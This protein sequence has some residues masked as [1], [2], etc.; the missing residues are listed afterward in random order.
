MDPY[1]TISRYHIPKLTRPG[2]ELLRHERTH[3]EDELMHR[4]LETV[5]GTDFF[6]TI[7]NYSEGS[8]ED[9]KKT[10]AIGAGTLDNL[11]SGAAT[12]VKPILWPIKGL[13][14]R[15]QM[16]CPNQTTGNP[17]IL[18]CKHWPPTPTAVL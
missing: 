4:A 5:E 17:T 2:V 7:L 12:I 3:H 9:G 18:S 14:T 10:I 8:S 16:G 15:R 13:T 1:R 6:D 11:S